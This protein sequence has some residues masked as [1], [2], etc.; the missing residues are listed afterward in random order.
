MLPNKV[1]ESIKDHDHHHHHHDGDCCDHNHDDGH[2]HAHVPIMITMLGGILV[3]NS[4]MAEWLYSGSKFQA[5]LSALLG[6][7]MIGSL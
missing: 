1:S 2:G 5:Q 6:A 7:L 4:F 3:L